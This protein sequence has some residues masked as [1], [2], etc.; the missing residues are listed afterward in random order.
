MRHRN[1]VKEAVVSLGSEGYRQLLSVCEGRSNASVPNYHTSFSTI[2]PP[3]SVCAVC[4]PVM[5]DHGRLYVKED[6]LPVYRDEIVPISSVMT[7]NQFEAEQLLGRKLRTE[8]EAIT[9]CQELH[10]RG[11]HTVVSRSLLYSETFQATSAAASTAM[12]C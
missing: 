12:P 7:P 1:A 3:K 10:G 11:P 6:I 2:E 8:R 9:A 4:D 5:G